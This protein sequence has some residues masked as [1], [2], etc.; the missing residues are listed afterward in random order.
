MCDPISVLII[1]LGVLG[2]VAITAFCALLA[3]AESKYYE[4]LK[5]EG[6]PIPWI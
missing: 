5:A 3:H 4:K 1:T 6:K 2:C